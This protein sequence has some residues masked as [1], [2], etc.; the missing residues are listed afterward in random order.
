MEA[1]AQRKQRRRA[2]VVKGERDLLEDT[3]KSVEK[4]Y[5]EVRVI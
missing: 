2:K 5:I 4:P 1:R 3:T